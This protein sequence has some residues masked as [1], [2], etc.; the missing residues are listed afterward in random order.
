[1]YCPLFGGKPLLKRKFWLFAV[2][3]PFSPLWALQWHIVLMSLFNL[4]NMVNYWLFGDANVLLRQK[5]NL[6]TFPYFLNLVNEYSWLFWILRFLR[7]VPIPRILKYG[8]WKKFFKS[9][10]ILT[11]LLQ[12]ART[13][14]MSLVINLAMR[15]SRP[16]GPNRLSP[17]SRH[18]W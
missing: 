11:H 5:D 10:S 1:M 3:V 18:I 9:V 15:S 4:P 6:K 12:K 13:S 2:N 8:F 17:K 16:N 7:W 14:Y